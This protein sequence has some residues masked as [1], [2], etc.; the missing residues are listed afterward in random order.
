MGWK[1]LFDSNLAGYDEIPVE[2]PYALVTA[3][4]FQEEKETTTLFQLFRER[5]IAEE[6]VVGA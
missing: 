4:S 2:D 3:S 5:L 6:G 1:E